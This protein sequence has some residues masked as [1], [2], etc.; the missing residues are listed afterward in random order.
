MRA[1]EED[2]GGS[3]LAKTCHGVPI[4]LLTL[5]ITLQAHRSIGK[6]TQLPDRDR[7]NPDRDACII[8]LRAYPH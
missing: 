5:A 8:D 7:G 2:S 1:C 4:H 6:F 3:Y